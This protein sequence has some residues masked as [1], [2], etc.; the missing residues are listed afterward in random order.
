[1]CIQNRCHNYSVRFSQNESLRTKSW[2]NLTCV[3]VCSVAQ[4]RLT[5]CD[6]MDYT[7]S[8]APLSI[9][10]SSQDYWSELPSPPPGA[11]PD[12]GVDPASPVSPALAGRIFTTEPPGVWVSHLGSKLTPVDNQCWHKVGNIAEVGGD[13]GI[14]V[15]KLRFSCSPL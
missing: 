9:G 5:L 15:T 8:Q 2:L 14:I 13:G 12:P 3:C 6:P 11:L 7:A 10:F 1:M 4:S